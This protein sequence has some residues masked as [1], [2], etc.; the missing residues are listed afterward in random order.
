LIVFGVVYKNGL[1]MAKVFDNLYPQIIEFSNL[2]KAWRKAAKGKRGCVA[3]ASFEMNLTDNL[4][5][6][7]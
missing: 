4:I 6:L 2:Y 1:K 5:R 3:A 7:Q